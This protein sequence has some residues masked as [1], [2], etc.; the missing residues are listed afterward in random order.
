MGWIHLGLGEVW[1]FV[2]R[3]FLRSPVSAVHDGGEM[4]CVSLGHGCMIGRGTVGWVQSDRNAEMEVMAVLAGIWTTVAAGVM[5]FES[6]WPCP[7]CQDRG[8]SRRSHVHIVVRGLADCPPFQ[9][10]HAKEPPG[11]VP[12]MGF[13][14]PS[15]RRYSTGV[16]T[17]DS[18]MKGRLEQAGD[19][20]D[21][22]SFKCSWS[23]VAVC[24][25]PPS[26]QRPLK[27]TAVSMM[28]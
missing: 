27:G 8:G 7:A 22:F 17:P 26:L 10:A 9:F 15:V 25:A 16:G 14:L 5:W 19:L 21:C 12:A 6:T 18:W 3:R 23:S 20:L 24:T 1:S 13:V 11:F 4:F 28:S 2:R